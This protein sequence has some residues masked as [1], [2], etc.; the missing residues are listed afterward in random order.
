[1]VLKIVLFASLILKRFFLLI[2]NY[3]LK[4]FHIFLENK[5]QFFCLINKLKNFIIF[6][7]NEGKY[8][9]TN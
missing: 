8:S 4:I 6:S 2:N 3:N 5:N 9:K 1:M 7:E